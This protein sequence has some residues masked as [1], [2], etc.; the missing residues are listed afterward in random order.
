MQTIENKTTKVAVPVLKDAGLLSTVS[1]HFGKSRGFIVVDSD[2]ANAQYLDSNSERLEHECAPI[3][4]LVNHGC[5]VLLCHSM[6]RGALA[7]SHEAGLLIYQAS[8]GQTVADVL[9]SFRAGASLDFPDSALCSPSSDKHAE[10]A[11]HH[12]C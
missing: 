10:G 6:G 8:R 5:R 7:R 11:H 2:G 9:V 1:A 4:S 12:E 3:R